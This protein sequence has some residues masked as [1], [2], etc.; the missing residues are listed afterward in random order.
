MVSSR[1]NYDGSGVGRDRCGALRRYRVHGEYYHTHLKDKLVPTLETNGS[2]I[3][4]CWYLLQ[5]L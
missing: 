4:H 3:Q 2:G 1:D 5:I